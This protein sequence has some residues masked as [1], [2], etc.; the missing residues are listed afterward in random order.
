MAHFLIH[1]VSTAMTQVYVIIGIIIIISC[2]VCYIFVR[3]TVIKRK[4]E[5]ARL[6][7]ALDKRSKDLVQMLNAFPPYFLPKDLQ[8][9]IY[10]CIVD[11]FEQLSKLEPNE[12]HYIDSYTLYTSQMETAARETHR[13]S[14]TNIQSSSQINELRQYLNYL[15]RFVQRWMQRGN[16]SSK[17]YGH[18]KTLIKTMITKLM[19]DNYMLSAKA[20]MDIQKHKLAAH[21]Y[22]LAKNL[23]TKEGL[24]SGNKERLQII[25]QELSSLKKRIAE[26]EAE[27]AELARQQSEENSEQN[28]TEEQWGKFQEDADWKKKNIYD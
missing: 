14:E 5:K 16:I 10:R 12:Q 11:V 3:Q 6:K 22:T 28:E 25:N 4:K 23:I 17:Q 19:V 15:G 8:V 20:A 24:L 9:F 26:E 21:Y 2:L 18:Y 27:Q 7:R 1:E 13:Q